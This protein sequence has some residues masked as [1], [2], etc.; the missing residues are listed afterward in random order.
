LALRT[1]VLPQDQDIFLE[2]YSG[3]VDLPNFAEKA[4]R[5]ISVWIFHNILDPKPTEKSLEILQKLREAGFTKF[6][7]PN[8]VKDHHLD[9]L[10]KHCDFVKCQN[11]PDSSLLAY[12]GREKLWNLTKEISFCKI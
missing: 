1:C 11:L 8:K 2:L 3:A 6:S 12:E 7:F 4:D 5:V 10:A 9:K